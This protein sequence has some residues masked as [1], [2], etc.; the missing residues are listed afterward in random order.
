MIVLSTHDMTIKKSLFS[1]K[2]QLWK[3]I[4]TYDC[5]GYNYHNIFSHYITEK[6]YNKIR[7][8]VHATVVN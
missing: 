1:K 2:Y 8:K 5:D 4:W 7:D 6:E 3:T